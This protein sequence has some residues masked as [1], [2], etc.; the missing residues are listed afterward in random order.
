MC[1][2]GHIPIYLYNNKN[3]FIGRTYRGQI[4]NIFNLQRLHLCKNSLHCIT[5]I[6]I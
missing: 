6:A 4:R 1:P 3:S 5:K 2:K